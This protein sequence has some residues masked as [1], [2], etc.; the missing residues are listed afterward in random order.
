MT[1]ARP[2]AIRAAVMVCV[3]CG[4]II[5]RRPVVMANVFAFAWLVVLVVNPT[6][7]FTAGCQLS[8]LSVFV[9]LW[10]AVR[11]LEPR[12]LTP[13]E[14]LIE[15][16]RG[17]PEKMLRALL[18]VLWQSFA[19]ST[20]ITVVNTPLVLAW[21]NVASPIGVILQHFQCGTDH[22]AANQRQARRRRLRQHQ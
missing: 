11:W 3:V 1:G 13:V 14:Q 5:L 20:I 9:L 4:G 15:E 2:S 10:G 19:I 6:D 18:R 8:F 16:T 21:Q 22:I 7:P 17:V 12:E